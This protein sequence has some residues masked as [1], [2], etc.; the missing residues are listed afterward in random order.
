MSFSKI[1]ICNRGEI[2]CRITRTACK[3]GYAT[4]AVFSDADR[5][6][7]HVSLAE[8]GRASCRERV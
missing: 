4:V 5:N 8:I 1:L 2:A 7:P 3:L 6:A